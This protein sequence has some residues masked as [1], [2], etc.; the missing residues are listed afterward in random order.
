[1]IS[2]FFSGEYCWAAEQAQ[3]NAVSGS[4]V[5]EIQGIAMGALAFIVMMLICAT[6]GRQRL[7][8]GRTVPRPADRPEFARRQTEVLGDA[9]STRNN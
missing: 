3:P 4:A 8:L 6:D 5:R 9:Y 1:V 7:G 2:Y